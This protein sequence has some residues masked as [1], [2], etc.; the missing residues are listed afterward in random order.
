[1][2][3]TVYFQPFSQPGVLIIWR[4]RNK[5]KERDG[6]QMVMVHVILDKTATGSQNKSKQ[7]VT[8]GRDLSQIVMFLH[9]KKPN[10]KTI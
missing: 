6:K 7:I 4:K 10:K 5:T 1:M 3:I 8:D 9:K 2:W